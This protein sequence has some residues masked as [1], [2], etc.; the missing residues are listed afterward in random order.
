MRSLINIYMFIV[1]L[2]AISL[3]T[4]IHVPGDYP[5]IQQAIDAAV[6]GDIVL[7]APGTYTEN[8]DFKGKAIT[9]KG[10]QGPSLTT[11]DGSKPL[12]PD[13]GSVVSFRQMEGSDS[14]LDGF[15]VTG[16]KGT[17]IDYTYYGGGIF[18]S[19]GSSPLIA[20]N[21]ITDNTVDGDGGG[22]Y[23]TL[24]SPVVTG[25]TFTKNRTT[26]YYP[27]YSMGGGF[28][29]ANGGKPIVTHC[30]FKDNQAFNGGGAG[31]LKGNVVLK[32]CSFNANRADSGGGFS[33]LFGSAE[34]F[35]CIFQGNSAESSIGWGGGI[36]V[37]SDEDVEFACC[38]F[39]ENTAGI[40]GGGSV[41]GHCFRMIQCTFSM[42]LAEVYGGGIDC[43][44]NDLQFI[45]CAFMD[46]AAFEGGGVI[47]GGKGKATWNRCHFKGNSAERGGGMVCRGG[48]NDQ[49]VALINSVFN[50]NT[51]L[52]VG[53]AMWND[54]D[55]TPTLTNCTLTLNTAARGGGLCNERESGVLVT[56]CIFWENTLVEIHNDADSH[57]YVGFSCIQGGYPGK[58]NFDADPRFV[59][60][61]GNDFHI[62][63]LSPCRGA[64]KNS[65]VTE[66]HD[67]EG[68]PRIAFGTVDMGADEF[69]THL[70]V[71]GD[72]TPGGTVQG[73]FV[74]LPGTMPVGLFIGT[75]V[76]P[77][78]MT[79]MWGD[80][81]LQAPWL[82][83][84]LGPIPNYGMLVLPTTLPPGMTAP[85]DIPLQALIGL[86]ADS[87]T[88]LYILEV[89]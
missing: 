56:S 32:H 64:G 33:D 89:R 77:S 57:C 62:S 35:H 28:C 15:T 55:A 65:A 80:F 34:V 1:V 19:N 78:P 31:V 36:D 69:F 14:V 45:D 82:L 39:V 18:C 43:S 47:F 72:K 70:Y 71:T 67:F 40:G 46:N 87:L 63:F 9:V 88:N 48:H 42:N 12:D 2:P 52:D 83:I 26:G 49:N 16:G 22:M 79:T 58:A 24:S 3:A 10:N 38:D 5:T 59:D 44:G 66:T 11:I 6:G 60:P 76:L 4:T 21:I 37:S 61:A 27:S 25:C 86:N 54:L 20:N 84:L 8:I 13:H 68:D 75:G 29:S 41:Y 7:V 50:H 17:L 53:G 30:V 23:S 73:K 74:G 51:A 85:I 81:W